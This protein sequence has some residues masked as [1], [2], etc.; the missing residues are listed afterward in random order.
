MKSFHFKSILVLLVS[1]ILVL[2]SIPIV[3][4]K[5]E[6]N[7]DESITVPS[8]Q[9]QEQA[10]A[11][12]QCNGLLDQCIQSKAIQTDSLSNE[13]KHSIQLKSQISSLE[14]SISASQD[15][16]QTLLQTAERTSLESSGKCSKVQEEYNSL[17]IQKNDV[18]EENKS[19]L[20]QKKAIQEQAIKSKAKFEKMT[21]SLREDVKEL[22]LTNQKLEKARDTKQE[23]YL[24]ARE[25]IQTLE[26]DFRI[27]MNKQQNMYFNFQ[28]FRDDVRWMLLKSFDKGMQHYDL[29]M[30]TEFVKRFQQDVW[31]P[32][33]RRVK[34]G[35]KDHL[36]GPVVQFEG[37]MRKVN[38]VEGVRRTLVS[39]VQSGAEI[40]LNYMELTKV[41][42]NKEKK[43]FTEKYM[44][45][46]YGKRSTKTG[47]R[48]SRGSVHFLKRA[49][50]DPEH[51]VNSGIGGLVALALFLIVYKFVKF[52]V[53]FSWRL[54]V[55]KGNKGK[56]GK[57]VKR[58]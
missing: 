28:L 40:G 16:E 10:Q 49:K 25:E 51:A 6:S 37:R 42:K 19:L 30:K 41:K 24:D 3:I 33:Q 7:V 34:T 23:Q 54:V 31:K 39:I 11:Q 26:K 36:Q 4:A 29:F 56:K 21:A 5:E 35:Y 12:A 27:V 46:R 9:E 50:N 57:K 48:W 2:S 32:F 58:E 17:L 13:I 14:L 43:S 47:G 8:L 44:D 22:H 18:Q 1:S 45:G 52:L 55:P 15:R 53:L 20:V 38:A